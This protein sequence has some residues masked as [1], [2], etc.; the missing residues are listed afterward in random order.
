M[1]KL[2]LSLVVLTVSLSNNLFGIFDSAAYAIEH[3]DSPGTCRRITLGGC[4][5]I[6]PCLSCERGGRG[7]ATGRY[8][9]EY[10]YRWGGTCGTHMDYSDD[11]Q[12]REQQIRQQ[13]DPH[14][15]LTAYRAVV[16]GGNITAYDQHNQPIAQIPYDRNRDIQT[17]LITYCN[18]MPGFSITHAATYADG[19]SQTDPNP[20]PSIHQE[21]GLNPTHLA[22]G[23]LGGISAWELLKLMYR[24]LFAKKKNEVPQQQPAQPTSVVAQQ[25]P[26]LAVAS[27][28]Q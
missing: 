2:T 9:V 17:C 28:Q 25:T 15:K 14:V 16:R 10:Y 8:T 7:R 26:A 11:A 22:V 12:K 3:I 23:A 1:N 18:I 24:Q 5:P 27:L 20:T 4:F 19:F 6:Q 13:L 21:H